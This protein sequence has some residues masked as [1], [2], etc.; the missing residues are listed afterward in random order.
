MYTVSDH[1]W[2]GLMLQY[3][4]CLIPRLLRLLA[5][6]A[7]SGLCAI[8]LMSCARAQEETLMPSKSPIVAADTSPSSPRPQSVSP[9]PRDGDIAIREEFAA[10]V[11]KGEIA[12]LKLFIRR[13]PQHALADIAQIMLEREIFGVPHPKSRD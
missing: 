4:R 9:R 1:A 12:A 5:F 3:L 7:V 6:A 10:A 2:C 13:H 11:V 8:A